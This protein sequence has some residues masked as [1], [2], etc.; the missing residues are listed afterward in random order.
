MPGKRELRRRRRLATRVPRQELAR[1]RQGRYHAREL[2]ET[3][4]GIVVEL[5]AMFYAL[6]DEMRQWPDTWEI[7]QHGDME[8]NNPHVW[9]PYEAPPWTHPT[10]WIRVQLEGGKCTC[11]MLEAVWMSTQTVYYS[12]GVLIR[13]VQ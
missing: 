3:Q 4:P 13:D 11:G 12:Q 7:D 2:Q 9:L 6:A 8:G 10:G 5:E 1:R